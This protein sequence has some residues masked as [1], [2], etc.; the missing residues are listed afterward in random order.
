MMDEQPSTSKKVKLCDP[1]YEEQLMKWYEEL[2]SDCSDIEADCD[3][4]HV[5]LDSEH[6]ADSETSSEVEEET[7]E[8][9]RE[10]EN[11]EMLE[12]E[13]SREIED[14]DGEND[15]KKYYYG[16]NRYKWS[17][18]PAT[19][20]RGRRAQE[21]IVVKLPGLRPAANLGSKA[22]PLTVW[23]LLFSDEV[24]DIILT[25]TNKKIGQERSKYDRKTSPTLKDLDKIEL[26]AFLGL[27]AFTSLFKSNNES[28]STLFAT[29]DKK[30]S[31][32]TQAV[33]YLTKPLYHTNRSVT[34][35]NW[36]TSI[37][38][39]KILKERG[40][41]C[42]GT[43]KK[44]KKEIPPA[45]LPNKNREVGTSLYG[46]TRDITILSYVPKKNKAVIL[47]SSSHHHKGDDLNLKKPY[48]ITDYN[49][50]KGGVDALDE[51]CAK[52]S[53]NRRT[54]RWPMA[55]FYQ[56]FDIS[57]VNA[58]IMYESYRDNNLLQRSVFLE[59]LAFQLVTPELERRS[60]NPYIQRNLR[61]TILRILDKPEGENPQTKLE[62]L[63]KRKNC[64]LC[65]YKL[66]R[67]TAYL[68]FNCQKPICLECA[69]KM[70][71]ECTQNI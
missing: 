54:C 3:E 26:Y 4:N 45:F 18:E 46:F 35:D 52:F 27:L 43:L 58:Y 61:L 41:T 53:C 30:Y 38:L 22:D 47:L 20:I 65:L 29:N 36:F 7:N 68:C 67:R 59:K 9:N 62:K 19:S 40:L 17:S 16:K 50:T 51:K 39:V 1:G 32:P 60:T 56:L 42:I 48:I 66:K 23:K 37:E 49:F 57:T 31:K 13:D 25:W 5:I 55:I 69:K 64:F 24:C 14:S 15:N 63:E 12:E 2:G 11:E 70:C 6:E 21:N 71:P 10:R 8:I 34:F 33:L 28:I 44:N